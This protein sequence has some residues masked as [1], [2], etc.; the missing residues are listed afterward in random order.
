MPW[1]GDPSWLADVIRAEGVEVRE[2]RDPD[3]TPWQQIGHGDFG[4]VWGV[5]WHHM[6]VNDQGANVIRNG[7]PGLDGPIANIHLS[8]DGVATIVSGGVA[9]HAGLGS[10]PGVPTNNGNFHLIGIEMAGNGTDPWPAKC[11]DAAVKIGA[12]ISRRLG[13]GADRNIAHKEYAG[14]AQGKWDP[15][16]WDMDA[17]RNQIQN[18]LDRGAPQEDVLDMTPEQLKA[19]IFECLDTYVGPIGSDVKDIRWQLVGARDNIPGDIGLSYPGHQFFGKGR[20]LDD[21]VA[22]IGEKLGVD[23]MHDP[24]AGGK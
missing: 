18:R 16:N 17:F 15:G 9:W 14:A 11:W 5:L 24:K 8:R 23:G 13:Y 19:L 10:W 7:V 20:T 1:N 2:W 4:N 6:G 22:A 12:A 3:G 21:A